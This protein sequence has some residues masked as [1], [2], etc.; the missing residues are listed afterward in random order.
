MS[1]KS[2]TAVARLC[3]LV[4]VTR[5]HSATDRDQLTLCSTPTAC[6]PRDSE[7]LILRVKRGAEYNYDDSLEEDV[8]IPPHPIHLTLMPI[9]DEE[10]S[11]SAEL[12]VSS[13]PLSYFIWDIPFPTPISVQPAPNV[14]SSPWHAPNPISLSQPYL[15]PILQVQPVSGSILQSQPTVQS[16]Q[17]S[18][19]GLNLISLSQPSRQSVS[20]TQPIAEPVPHSQ[21]TLEADQRPVSPVQKTTIQSQPPL[22]FTSPPQLI[23]APVTAPQPT[24]TIILQSK[25]ASG[26]LRSLHFPIGNTSSEMLHR[27]LFATDN[28][29]DSEMN[30]HILFPT[31]N[32]SDSEMNHRILFP[33]DNMSAIEILRP[34]LVPLVTAARVQEGPIDIRIAITAPLRSCTGNCFYRASNGMCEA[35]FNCLVRHAGS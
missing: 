24:Q 31:D 10:S 20:P 34:I 28:T 11:D 35:A 1:W 21:V 26:T 5:S 15:K 17:H 2:V 8:R 18:Q 9:L 30:H 23:P 3:M 13:W 7:R 19:P 32:T 25:S 33:I 6:L 29:S 4:C 22:S 27:I 14:P 12:Q 16:I